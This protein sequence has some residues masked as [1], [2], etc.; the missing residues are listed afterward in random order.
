MPQLTLSRKQ[1][2]SMVGLCHQQ[3]VAFQAPSLQLTEGC[4]S[5]CML[6]AAGRGFYRRRGAYAVPHLQQLAATDQPSQQ[7]TL[8]QLVLN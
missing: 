4:L 7:V 2:G 5:C 8:L 3:W 6:C 1:Q